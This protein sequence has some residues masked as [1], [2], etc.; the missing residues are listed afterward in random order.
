M[1]GVT[2]QLNRI[3]ASSMELQYT[4]FYLCY[5]KKENKFDSQMKNKIRSKSK[6]I[7]FNQLYTELK[8]GKFK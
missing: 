5:P 2:D 3:H 1:Y 8:Y 7:S 4:F 6:T